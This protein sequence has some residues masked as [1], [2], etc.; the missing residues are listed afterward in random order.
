MYDMYVESYGK[1]G[2]KLW[3][4]SA[5][6]L[7]RYPCSYIIEQD[8]D[9]NILCY[10]MYQLREHAN[11]ISLIVHNST[12]EGKERVINLVSSLL[13]KRGWILEASGAVSW[14]L[15]K[16]GVSIISTKPQIEKM[17]GI[18][19]AD[20]EMIELNSNFDYNN[21]SVNAYQ[22]KYYKDGIV[23]FENSETLFGTGGCRFNQ[24]SC[25]RACIYHPDT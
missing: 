2:E 6:D 20:S 19:D 1:A 3:F 21:K 13:S 22:H 16:K 23:M 25:G 12:T 8:S 15:R 17:L 7:A 10:I 9:N 24:D 14:V 4:K 18:K 11:K 5:N